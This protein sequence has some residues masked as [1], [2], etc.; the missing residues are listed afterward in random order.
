V[1]Q[2]IDHA[3]VIVKGGNGGDGSTSFYRAAYVPKGGPDGGNGGRGGDVI[4]RASPQ[5]ATLEDFALK[6][7]YVGESGKAGSSDRKAGKSAKD[8]YVDMPVGT[9]IYDDE[10]GDILA[11]LTEPGE[12]FMAAKGGRGGRGNVNFATSTNRTPQKAEEGRRGK[13]RRLRL[14]LKLLADVGLLGRPNAGKST[15]LSALT[16]ATPRIAD[17]PFS[18]LTPNLG[19]V[20]VGGYQRFVM[21]DIPGVI[22][23]ASEGKG[24]GHFFLRHIER[25]RLIVVLIETPELDYRQAYKGLVAEL[26]NFSDELAALPRLIVRSKCDL[27]KPP[28]RKGK[29]HFDMVLSGVSGEGLDEFV[30]AIAA[31]LGII[32]EMPE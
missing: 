19:V 28:G 5:L 1:K 3:V 21:A 30:A 18:T 26:E 14:E 8:I 6:R 2:F 12:I 11:D 23:G 7:S 17:Y 24:L 10:T 22:E 15:L 13:E 4:F 9:I 29:M 31:R 27:P 25:T 20:P 16:R 32:S